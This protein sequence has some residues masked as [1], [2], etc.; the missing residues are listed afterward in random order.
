MRMRTLTCSLAAGIAALALSAGVNAY[1]T[2]ARW[3]SPTAT[4]YVN[5][6]NA[7]VSA[8]SAANALQTALDVWN[9]Q[10]DSSF[11][12]YYG[13]TVSDTSTGYDGRNVTIFRND[14]S[15]S[16]IATTYSWWNGSN[17]LLDSDV[18]FWD[19]GFT[20]FTGSSGCGSG[21]YIEDVATHE[22]G[23]VLGLNHSDSADAT[24]YY[25][26]S[27]CTQSGRTLSSDDIAGVRS[28]YS[29]SAAPSNSAP[30]VSISTPS[31]NA[32]YAEGTS[33][34]FSGSSW[35]TQ[36]GDLTG[37]IQWTDNGSAIFQ[38]GAFSLALAVGTH[39]IVARVTDSANADASK[40]IT[41]TVT[42]TT[43]G[44]TG[45]STGP[46]ANRGRGKKK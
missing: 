1:T 43:S 19:G 7:D 10:G 4:M 8:A 32:S 39:T 16:A 28:L 6:A 37:S 5:P 12:F 30:S 3:A 23:H 42:G 29:G 11:R 18:I 27:A 2:Y 17:Q 21:A 46:T 26:Y 22:Y 35:D 40:T 13:G 14:S 38:G 41:V 25:S 34:S 9:T 24:M 33:V 31:N 36:D 20:F 45:G 44:S 15:G